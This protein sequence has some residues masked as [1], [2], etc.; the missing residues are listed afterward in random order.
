MLTFR[1]LIKVVA[2][3]IV[4]C[5]DVITIVVATCC[6][7]RLKASCTFIHYLNKVVVAVSRNGDAHLNLIT[8]LERFVIFC[9][10]HFSLNGDARLRIIHL[11]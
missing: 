11:G 7:D 2:S 1:K 8:Y 5:C 10:L 6:V 9:I 4:L 3:G